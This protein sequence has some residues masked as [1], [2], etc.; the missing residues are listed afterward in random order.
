MN[1]FAHALAAAVAV[2][3]AALGCGNGDADAR[4][5]SGATRIGDR[6][7]ASG[8][9]R[10]DGEGLDEFDE[11]TAVFDGVASADQR[12]RASRASRD[13][14]IFAELIAAAATRS[15]T[16]IVGTALAASRDPMARHRLAAAL[17]T[18]GDATHFEVLLDGLESANAYDRSDAAA[19]LADVANRVPPE[20]ESRT[21][22]LLRAGLAADAG[23]VTARGYERSLRA[24][25]GT[26]RD[27]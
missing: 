15:E 5:A 9:D 8:V 6:A 10:S 20:L 17:I 21:V 11:L 26:H 18:L 12:K 4:H 22:E 3:C 16:D 2:S 25:T 23:G 13:E 7:P 24:L 14:V 1:V 27:H 19:I